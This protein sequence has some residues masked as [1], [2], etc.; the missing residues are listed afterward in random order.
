MMKYSK[1]KVNGHFGS[2]R[3]NLMV[4]L[5]R[6]ENPFNLFLVP[7]ANDRCRNPAFPSFELTIRSLRNL[8]LSYSRNNQFRILM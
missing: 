6:D 1:L 8:V 4:E 5:P 2:W 3:R 7:S